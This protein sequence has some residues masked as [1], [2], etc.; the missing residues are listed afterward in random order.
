MKRLTA[1]VSGK[2]Q[3]VGYRA[4]VIQLANGMGLKG[5]IENLSDGR[6]RIIA[7]GDEE[8]MKLFEGAIDIK[9]TFIQ[10]T[11]IEKSY[12]QP[13]GEFDG[14]FKLVGTGETD[15]RLD[16]GISVLKDMRDILISICGMQREMLGKQDQMLG[17]QDQMLGKQD[18]MLVKQDQMLVK[19]DETILEIKDMNRNLSDKIDKALDK[20]EI[21]ELKSDV[22]EMKSALKAKGII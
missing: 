12:S 4:R 18:Q 13:Y 10:V 9:N 16:E 11:S 5:I 20:S 22:S 21:I 14:F 17:K 3:R 2:V 15:S 1:F 7:E 8:K 19:Q 6:V